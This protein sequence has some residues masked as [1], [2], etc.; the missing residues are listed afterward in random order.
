L[1]NLREIRVKY[2]G[3]LKKEIKDY[4]NNL[5]DLFGCELDTQRELRRLKRENEI[6][7]K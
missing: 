5:K 3:C 2:I 4:W 7:I 1:N 6:F